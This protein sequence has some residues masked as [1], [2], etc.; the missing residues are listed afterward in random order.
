MTILVAGADPIDAGKTTFS[1]GL[2]E[3][4]DGTG[5][6][7]RAGNDYW[8]D[9]DDYRAVVTEGR[10]YG[11]DARQLAKVS[12]VRPEAINPVHRLWRPAP[13][14]DSFI[15]APDRMF[16]LD[17][18]GDTY[19]VNEDADLPESARSHLPLDEA[20]RVSSVEELN[21]VIEENYL[22]RF[23]ALAEQINDCEDAV[24]E[25]YGDVARPLRDIRVERVAVVEPGRV[26]IYPGDRYWDACE[27]STGRPE[28]GQ[29]EERV[30]DVVDLLEP[31]ATVELPPV[32]DAARTDPS[33]IASAYERA[34]ASLVGQRH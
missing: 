1:L 8:F 21:R 6:K 30:G 10:L 15:G 28:T 14:G 27:I 26:R 17:R 12:G 7:P 4:L 16:L 11:K 9:Y 31:M 19:V 22:P 29:L 5:F 18:I 33:Q 32:S 24:V 23:R 2:V 34:Y 13:R 25:S 3:T 20:V